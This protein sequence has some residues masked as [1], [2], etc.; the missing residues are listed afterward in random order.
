MSNAAATLDAART[1]TDTRRAAIRAAGTGFSLGRML[2][3][4][5]KE[6]RSYFAFPLVYVL[7][8]VFLVLAGYYAYTDL[9]FFVTI[10]FA[11]DIMQNYWQLLF[12]DIR[13]CMLLTLPFITMRLFAEERKLGTIELLYTYPLRDGEVL[14]GKYLASVA[15]FFMILVLTMVYPI[16]LYSVHS[17]PL[18]P[19]VAGYLGLLLLGCAFIACGV[20]IS[21]LCESQ[22]MAG[23]GT[24]VLLLLFW[25]LNWNEAA[26]NNSYLELLRAFSLFDQFG[27]FAKGVI[28]LDH[29]TYFVFFIAFFL[30]LTQRSMEARKWT[31]RR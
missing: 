8:G 21:S 6:L 27:S 14:G 12:S 13:L 11:H 29:V 4:M 10:A 18:F 28:D 19:L 17:F 9:V 1:A 2:A 22:V 23:M 16:F 25:I 20:F 5:R 26:F 3:V 31:G 24:I 7:S 30:F 15:I